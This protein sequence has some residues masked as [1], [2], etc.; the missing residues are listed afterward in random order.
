MPDIVVRHLGIYGW[1]RIG[2]RW[3]RGEQPFVLLVRSA[4]DDLTAYSGYCTHNGC[5][6]A[7]KEAELDCPCHGS[8]FDAANGEVLVRAATRR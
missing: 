1:G 5:A 3:P 2:L 7:Q 4:G 8:R 6:L